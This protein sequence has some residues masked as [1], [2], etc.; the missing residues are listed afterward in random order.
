MAMF[1]GAMMGLRTQA[2][3]PA[4][5]SRVAQPAR[6]MSAIRSL[7]P[8]IMDSNMKYLTFIVGGAVAIEF[9]YGFAAD[10]IWDSANTGK[11]PSHVDWSSWRESA[12]DEDDDEDD[13]DDDD[14]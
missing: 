5:V 8:T 6:K 7:Y 12:E 9:V 13:D 2:L 1:R 3:R 4:V 10:A 11:L 14:E